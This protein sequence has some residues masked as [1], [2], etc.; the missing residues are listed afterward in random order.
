[1]RMNQ[2]PAHTGTAHWGCPRDLLVAAGHG[3]GKPRCA[4]TPLGFWERPRAHGHRALSPPQ[5]TLVGLSGTS[6]AIGVPGGPQ[7]LVKSQ[8]SLGLSQGLGVL[9]GLCDV[10]RM[11]GVPRSRLSSRASLRAMPGLGG[12]PH[13]PHARPGLPPTSPLGRGPQTFPPGP[14][15]RPAAPARPPAAPVVPGAERGGVAAAEAGGGGGD[16]AAEPRAAAGGDAGIRR[17]AMAQ[18]AGPALRLLLVLLQLLVLPAGHGNSTGS[19]ESGWLGEGSAVRCPLGCPRDE[20][21]RAGLGRRRRR[22]GERPP[23]PG[24]PAVVVLPS[25]L[26]CSPGTTG[27][28]RGRPQPRRWHRGRRVSPR[29]PGRGEKAKFVRRHQSGC[30]RHA[31]AHRGGSGLCVGPLA[32]RRLGVCGVG[33][34]MGTG[35]GAQLTEV[36]PGPWKP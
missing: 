16:G 30:P 24:D 10:P 22:R 7:G 8:G 25:A 28:A 12:G 5:V 21:S 29:L 36:A 35:T 31:G 17:A 15:Q 23:L 1:M 19:G 18:G 4:G 33:T 2:T 9:T 6:W 13:Q 32:R 14:S 34:G 3:P 11:S 26:L 20:S 27:G